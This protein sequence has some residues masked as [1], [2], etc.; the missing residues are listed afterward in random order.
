MATVLRRG[1]DSH[2]HTVLAERELPSSCAQWISIIWG[3]DI[4]PI[5][6]RRVKP[7]TQWQVSAF[8]Q[9]MKNNLLFICSK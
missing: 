4:V 5:R 6:S 2:P 9:L 3:E 1:Q 7:Q 8:L